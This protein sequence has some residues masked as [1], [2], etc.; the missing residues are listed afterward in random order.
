MSFH[1]V[2]LGHVC[3][4]LDILRGCQI[5]I[6]NHLR[7]NALYYLI[8]R[9]GSTLKE[10]TS[11]QNGTHHFYLQKTSCIVTLGTQNLSPLSPPPGFP[12]LQHADVQ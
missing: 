8:L 6:Q 1:F 5:P 12:L 9:S 7:A 11:A 10:G 2:L 4:V 3:F